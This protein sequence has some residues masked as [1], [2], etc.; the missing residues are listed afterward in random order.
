M[1]SNY[2]PIGEYIRRIDVR[3]TDLRIENLQGIRINKEFMP[4]VANVIGTDLSTYKVVRKHQFAYNPMHVGRDKVLP[5]CV[6]LDEEP[7]IVSPAYVVFEI[8]DTNVLLPEYLM[9]WCRRSEFDRNAW[10]MTD[11]SVR[12]GF[13]CE[14]FCNMTLPVPDIAAQHAIVN[15][16]NSIVKRIRLNAEINRKLE[17]TAQAIYT[18]WFVDFDFPDEQGRPYKFSGGEMVYNEELDQEIPKGW[19]VKKWGDLCSLEYGKGLKGYRNENGN[20]PVF[21]TNGQIGWTTEPLVQSDGI[22]IGRKGVYRGVHYSPQPF[23][24][25][26]TAFFLKPTC[27]ISI[28][29]AFFEI[30]RFDING[31]GNRFCYSIYKS[32]RFL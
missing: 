5:I 21:G 14:D 1:K 16:Y 6:L 26:D 25:I 7:I 8:V 32:R 23:F 27:P 17:E 19:E 28:K 20:I 13:S 11:S 31:M 24:V 18:H 29:W 2:T 30:C 12:G 4:S 15:E 10:F 22:I 3:N 9:M